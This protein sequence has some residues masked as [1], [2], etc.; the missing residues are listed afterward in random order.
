MKL[1]VL[2]LHFGSDPYLAISREVNE[3]YCRQHGIEFRVAEPKH[4]PDDRDP[5]WSKV[6]RA[7]EALDDVD[8]LLYLDADAVFVDHAR[9]PWWLA[10]R[11]RAGG[12]DMLIGEDFTP[13]QANTGVWLVRNTSATARLLEDWQTAPER[14][15]SLVHRWPLDEAGF[16]EQVLAKHRDSIWLV[17]GPEFVRGPFI[18]HH[19]A[20]PVT[21]KTRKLERE[22]RILRERHQ[23][24]R[25]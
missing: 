14:D 19:M 1:R 21:A 17:P 2:T 13:G 24:P 7:R 25:D 22:R 23:W 11:L 12:R 9:D 8:F 5:L 6:T 16:N 18:R 20:E 4:H 10:M 3:R 15:P